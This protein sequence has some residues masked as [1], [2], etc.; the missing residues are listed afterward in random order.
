MFRFL[1]HRLFNHTFTDSAKSRTS[2]SAN[3]PYDKTASLVS[4]LLDAT[5]LY[6]SFL[7]EPFATRHRY[8]TSILPFG[9]CK[10]V[11]WLASRHSNVNTLT[12][13]FLSCNINVSEK[14]P[15]SHDMFLWNVV[16]ARSLRHELWPWGTDE[17]CT[18]QGHT[19]HTERTCVLSTF[20]SAWRY[21]PEDEHKHFHRREN[22]KSHKADKLRSFGMIDYLCR[23]KNFDMLY[24]SKQFNLFATNQEIKSRLNSESEVQNCLPIFSTELY[25][26]KYQLYNF[27]CSVHRS[28]RLHRL[29]MFETM[30]LRRTCRSKRE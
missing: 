7:I 25:K 22:L 17:C 14:L 16:T 2:D 4:H 26:W 19:C 15:V 10:Q 1:K 13:G 8:A 24:H 18:T 28:L 12:N 29:T 23:S 3:T 30:V 20:K 9:G 5:F 11:M 6:L 27:N 21:K